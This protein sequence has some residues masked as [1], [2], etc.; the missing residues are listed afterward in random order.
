MNSPAFGMGLRYQSLRDIANMVSDPKAIAMMAQTRA[1]LAFT[2][3]DDLPPELVADPDL[4]HVK[5]AKAPQLRKLLGPTFKRAF[6]A[7]KEK[8]LG[9]VERYIGVREEAPVSIDITYTNR[10]PQFLYAIRII[11][12]TGVAPLMGFNFEHLWGAGGGWDLITEDKA[13]EE[14]AFLG[15][16]VREA[17]RLR[18]RVFDLWRAA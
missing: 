3:R 5:P 1:T 10:G 13:E 14:I 12:E 16:L 17:A 11:D 15:D 9:G 7:V 18:R 4:T 6:A 2:P 8:R